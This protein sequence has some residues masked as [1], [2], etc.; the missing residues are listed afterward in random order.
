MIFFRFNIQNSVKKMEKTNFGRFLE[1]KSISWPFLGRFC[2]FFFFLLQ[3]NFFQRFKAV[4]RPLGWLLGYLKSKIRFFCFFRPI[5]TQFWGSSLRIV[6]LVGW[7]V[8]G[9]CCKK[10]KSPPKNRLKTVFEHP[11][12]KKKFFFLVEKNFFGGSK[13]FLSCRGLMP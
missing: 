4:F 6:I 13:F 11:W 1:W 10:K 2:W 7:A 5:F 3:K 12:T 8:R 9:A